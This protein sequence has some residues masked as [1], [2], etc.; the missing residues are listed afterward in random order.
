MRDPQV[1]IGGVRGWPSST[2]LRVDHPSHVLGALIH[3]VE[4]T[5]SSDWSTVS[6]HG[7]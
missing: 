3:G 7:R 5:A 6:P 2:A 4:A 1:A